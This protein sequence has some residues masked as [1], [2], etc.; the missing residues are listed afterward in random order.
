M[1]AAT[2]WMGYLSSN[3]TFIMQLFALSAGASLASSC[4]MILAPKVVKQ[5]RLI[6]ASVSFINLFY[7]VGIFVG[8][9]IVTKLSEGDQSWQNSIYL[10]SGIGVI[11]LLAVVGFVKLNNKKVLS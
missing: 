10:L 1:L 2:F 3:V 9:P 5:D 4:V 8:T 6:G 11:A 7:Y